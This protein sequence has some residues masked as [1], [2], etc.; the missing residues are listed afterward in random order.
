MN[1]SKPSGK[2]V[3]DTNSPEY[4]EK[5]LAGQG[6]P[7]EPLSESELAEMQGVE[8]VSISELGNQSQAIEKKLYEEEP[9]NKFGG[10]PTSQENLVALVGTLIS[11]WIENGVPEKI[12]SIMSHSS[13]VNGRD[14]VTVIKNGGDRYHYTTKMIIGY[15]RSKLEKFLERS[16]IAYSISEH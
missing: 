10:F 11:E 9:R 15:S 13:C 6:M 12:I 4:W 3:D 16:S 5:L 1:E 7:A 14:C 8:T 2:S